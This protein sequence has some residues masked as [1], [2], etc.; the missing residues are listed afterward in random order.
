MVGEWK[1]YLNCGPVSVAARKR[2]ELMRL[3][4]EKRK[5]EEQQQ[6]QEE[7]EEEERQQQLK[8]EK[9]R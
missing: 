9:G 7:E 5:Y 8:K 2:N 6:Q 1:F 4:I 3:R